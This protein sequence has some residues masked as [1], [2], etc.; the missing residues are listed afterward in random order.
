MIA[1]V[2]AVSQNAMARE[3]VFITDGIILVATIAGWET[4]VCN[5]KDHPEG[6][7]STLVQ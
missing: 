2:V 6:W 4:A 7:S 1:L 5:K 3:H